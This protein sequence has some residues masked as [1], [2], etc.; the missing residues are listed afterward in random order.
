MFWWETYGIASGFDFMWSLSFWESWEEPLLF[1]KTFAN[2]EAQIHSTEPNVPYRGIM[3]E[4]GFPG[5]THSKLT[6]PSQGLI[7]TKLDGG[8]SHFVGEVKW[9]LVNWSAPVLA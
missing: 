3:Q 2:T 9:N 8:T 1:L 5:G 7:F 4:A 6:L